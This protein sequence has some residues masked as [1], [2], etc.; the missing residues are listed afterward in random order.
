MVMD[1]SFFGDYSY[2]HGNSLISR[3]PS[4]QCFDSYIPSL[5]IYR[6]SSKVNSAQI[7]AD[8]LFNLLSFLVVHQ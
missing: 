1:K 8:S 3:L 4:I 7:S 2:I 5:S 6:F